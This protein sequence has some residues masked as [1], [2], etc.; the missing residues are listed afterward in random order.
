MNKKD[1]SVICLVFFITRAFF[2]LYNFNNLPSLLITGISTLLVILIIKTINK[3]LFKNKILTFLYLIIIIFIFFIILTKRTDFI[4]NNYFIHDNN[5]VIALSLILIAYIINNDNIKT[6]ASISEVLILI[7][8]LITSITY[9]GLLSIIKVNNYQGYLNI[10]SINISIYPFLLIFV[11][12]YIK[13]KNITGGYI[14]G[15][16]S[17][18]IDNI[19]FIGSLGIKLIKTYQ[20]PSV[21]ILKSLNFFNFINHLD[22]FFSIIYLF[23]YTITLSFII[24]IIKD[25][26]NKYF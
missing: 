22:K 14:L 2:S 9:I 25:I 5:I 17:F 4:N 18:S 21:A 26:I 3:N 8:L 15:L 19:L 7:F 11:L 16:I 1:L 23:E 20:I 10:N 24:F 6:L 12:L 13:N